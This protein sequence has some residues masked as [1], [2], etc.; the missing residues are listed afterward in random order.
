M[1][2]NPRQTLSLLRSVCFN[3]A[4]AL[5]LHHLRNRRFIAARACARAGATWRRF[6]CFAGSLLARTTTAEPVRQWQVPLT[7]FYD[8]IWSQY[9][10][11]RNAV[12]HNL[13]TMA[14]T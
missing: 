2:L 1:A 3:R 14:M 7:S 12:V 9:A 10:Y 5:R 4:G 11:G 8:T 13:A 6:W